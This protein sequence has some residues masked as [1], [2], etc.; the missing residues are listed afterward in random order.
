M[1]KFKPAP[2]YILDEV[3]AALDLSHTQNIGHML[4]THFKES[5]VS[6]LFHVLNFQLMSRSIFCIIKQMAIYSQIMLA[7][8]LKKSNESD[9][10]ATANND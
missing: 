7:E 5:Q 4:K 2:L 3:D 1:L 9:E 8:L 6:M 10:I